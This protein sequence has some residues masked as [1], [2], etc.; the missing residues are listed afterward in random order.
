MPESQHDCY[1]LLEET[2]RLAHL[3]THTLKSQQRLNFLLVSYFQDDAG[4]ACFRSML[5][6]GRDDLLV[7][8]KE[9]NEFAVLPRSHFFMELHSSTVNIPIRFHRVGLTKRKELQLHT[10]KAAQASV[11]FVL[12]YLIRHADFGD[13]DIAYFHKNR[14]IPLSWKNGILALPPRAKHLKIVDLPTLEDIQ[15]RICESLEFSCTQKKNNPMSKFFTEESAWAWKTNASNSAGKIDYQALYLKGC[16]EFPSYLGELLGPDQYLDQLAGVDVGHLYPEVEARF[17]KM[18]MHAPPR[19]VSK[20]DL[21]LGKGSSEIGGTVVALHQYVSPSFLAFYTVDHDSSCAYMKDVRSS[22]KKQ[23]KIRVASLDHVDTLPTWLQFGDTTEVYLYLSQ[24]AS[25]AEEKWLFV[26]N[27]VMNLLVDFVNSAIKAEHGGKVRQF[28]LLRKRDYRVAVGSA[29]NPAEGNFGWHQDGKNG[30]VVVGDTNYS[31]FQLMVPTLCLQNYSHSN[32]T[33]EW[34]PISEP[35]F[36]AGTVTQECIL[37]HI[38][39]LG[40]N[41]KFRHHVSFVSFFHL[42]LCLLPS[43]LKLA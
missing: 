11:D 35:N 40:V 22:R 36:I 21:M 23:R 43:G 18:Y 30:I 34:A 41:E 24:K 12:A 13:K 1:V 28:E 10:L 27:F 5:C 7:S 4:G 42:L 31:T 19:R 17:E 39:L 37:L 32:T 29:S 16:S 6:Y 26:V 9:F 33:I 3:N 15:S 14:K 8:T 25:V 20:Q 2:L 38:Q